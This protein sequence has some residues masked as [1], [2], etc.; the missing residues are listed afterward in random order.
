MQGAASAPGPPN[1]QRST[2]GIPI[3]PRMQTEP[4]LAGT[5]HC[6]L[7]FPPDEDARL[8]IPHIY[9]EKIRL[10]WEGANTRFAAPDFP[11]EPPENACVSDAGCQR[12]RRAKQV[13]ICVL[14]SSDLLLICVCPVVLSGRRR[15]PLQSVYP[16]AAPVHSNTVGAKIVRFSRVD[17]VRLGCGLRHPPTDGVAG[18]GDMGRAVARL[19]MVCS[20]ARCT[21]R[22]PAGS[23]VT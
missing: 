4:G 19:H 18:G 16:V 23:I 21:L 9:C 17:A 1:A 8:Q 2:A 14:P 6:P 15:I 13:R 3:T 11:H 10:V 12:V 7:S 20:K 22:R 5:P